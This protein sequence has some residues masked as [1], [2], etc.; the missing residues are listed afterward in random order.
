V[1]GSAIF[2]ILGSSLIRQADSWVMPPAS[3]TLSGN[4]DRLFYFI[5]YLSLLFFVLIVGAMVYFAVKYRYRAD[6]IHTSSNHGNLPLEIA[7]TAIPSVLFVVIFV[8]GVSTFIDLSVP[9][10][11]SYNVRV[12]ARQW[13]WSF[14]YPDTGITSP[15]LVVPAGRPI[16]LTMSSL[17]V[18][19]GF[20]VPDFRI[21]RDVL[22]NRYT[23]LWFQADDP[24]E[25]VVMCT[26]YCGTGHSKMQSQVKVL[27]ETD[28][29]IWRKTQQAA[30]VGLSGPELGRKLYTEKGCNACH[31]IDGSK[32]IGPT[33]KGR[34]GE[35]VTYTDGTT[36][37]ADDNYL[38]EC[39]LTPNKKVLQ[40]YQ[41]IMPPFKGQLTDQQIDALIDFIKSL[42]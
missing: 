27:S 20:Y 14:F 5:F 32:I 18:I 11:N 30:S 3:S 29:E 26:Q 31:S 36:A 28:F 25:H 12:T 38:R 21:K 17:D 34:Y 8:W 22:P 41:P 16:R 40:G 6:R 4:V 1:N 2:H 13:S 39:I 23:I 33:F 42:K 37:V 9:P 35:T 24:G 19:H 10:G 7:W 15:D